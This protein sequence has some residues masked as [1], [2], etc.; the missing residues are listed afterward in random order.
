MHRPETLG[1]KRDHVSL[2]GPWPRA[3][4]DG[5]IETVPRK[6]NLRV[7]GA[8]PDI[9]GGMALAKAMQARDQPFHQKRAE[10]GNVEMTFLR[11]GDETHGRIHL[12]EGR[13][14][15]RQQCPT[16]VGQLRSVFRP[17]E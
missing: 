12:V 7:C 6:I 11:I 1:E 2:T 14:Q 5:D 16:C 9:D 13:T 15:R 17:L 8:D 10:A 3:D 4:A